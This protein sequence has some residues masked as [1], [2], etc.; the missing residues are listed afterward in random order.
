MATDIVIVFDKRELQT[1]V[2]LTS[3]GA[4]LVLCAACLFALFTPTTPSRSEKGNH[5]N[6][7]WEKRQKTRRN[8]QFYE[9]KNKKNEAPEYPKIPKTPENKNSQS[10][11]VSM[12]WELSLGPSKLPSRSVRASLILNNTAQRTPGP[13]FGQ[14]NPVKTMGA[15]KK[16]W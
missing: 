8:D 14:V 11:D 6:R 1:T 9:K 12:I 7:E 2:V 10:I 3:E 15:K 5:G 13:L 4:E 16:S